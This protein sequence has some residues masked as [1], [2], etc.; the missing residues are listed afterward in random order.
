MSEQLV[1]TYV[2]RD[3]L[4]WLGKTYT[5]DHKKQLISA[6]A[7]KYLHEGKDPAK[8]KK[9]KISIRS[10]LEYLKDEHDDWMHVKPE[11]MKTTNKC[12]NGMN[13]CLPRC[14]L[15][16]DELKNIMEGIKRMREFDE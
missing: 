16:V 4:T 14:Q 3:P 5:E 1:D 13:I 12:I 15:L 9:E 11:Q 2:P 10:M 7:H 6:L 8:Q